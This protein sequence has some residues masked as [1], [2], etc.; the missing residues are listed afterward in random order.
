MQPHIVYPKDVNKRVLVYRSQFLRLILRV[1]GSS[2]ETDAEGYQRLHHP[3]VYP[4]AQREFLRRKGMAVPA[5]DVLMVA[6]M[7]LMMAVH[8][9]ESMVEDIVAGYS[10]YM[11]L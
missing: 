8:E 6:W 2:D 9:N 1:D 7:M 4:R 3:V 10:L 5:T 11:L